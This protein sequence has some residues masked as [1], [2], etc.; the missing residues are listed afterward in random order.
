MTTLNDN[1][2]TTA[3]DNSRPTLAEVPVAAPASEEEK[4]ARDYLLSALRKRAE[5]FAKIEEI[6]DTKGLRL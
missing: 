5:A 3:A 4:A 2:T 1:P 6:L